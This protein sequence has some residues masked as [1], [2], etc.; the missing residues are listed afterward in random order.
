MRKI[1]WIDDYPTPVR[2]QSICQLIQETEGLLITRR[3]LNEDGSKEGRHWI[4]QNVQTLRSTKFFG[5]KL[6]IVDAQEGESIVCE[7]TLPLVPTLI[8]NLLLGRLKN[9]IV[10]V[11]HVKNKNVSSLTKTWLKE[12]FRAWSTS[13][14]V[15]KA[16]AVNYYSELSYEF[17]PPPSG[18]PYSI[19]YGSPIDATFENFVTEVAAQDHPSYVMVGK[20]N[21]RKNFSA[22]A[23]KM[24]AI[25]GKRLVSV[26]GKWGDPE[27]F[28]K[29][30][31]TI[32]EHER[33]NAKLFSLRRAHKFEVNP[34]LQEPWGHVVI[35][36]MR[37]G[38]VPIVS[39]MVGSAVAVKELDP[40]LVFDPYSDDDIRR[41]IQ[42]AESIPS[43]T[44]MRLSQEC[45][46]I[47]ERYGIRN[48]V[49]ALKRLF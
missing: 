45:T 25:P 26:I 35:E 49:E 7:A 38:I 10:I 16:V 41:V 13:M 19:G 31:D 22:F 11:G 28:A 5:M 27:E 37:A 6:G 30:F 40:Q 3:Y 34:A 20:V 14:L 2:E 12:K 1:L 21:A 17:C 39:K 15:R 32:Y 8:L 42:Y 23:E 9:Y 29:H 36:G 46:T 4:Y 43:T 48:H 24:R 18:T 44:Y 33:D 47:A